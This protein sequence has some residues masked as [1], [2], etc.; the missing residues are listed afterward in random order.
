[1]TEALMTPPQ[2]VMDIKGLDAQNGIPLP[3]TKVCTFW[4]KKFE[5][6]KSIFDMTKIIEKICYFY[7]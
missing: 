7:K 5:N 3:T 1:M 4:Y 6:T 2:G